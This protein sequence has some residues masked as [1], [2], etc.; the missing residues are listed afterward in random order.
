MRKYFFL[1]PLLALIFSCSDPDT[2]KRKINP[3]ARGLNDT[4][5]MLYQSGKMDNIWI[6]VGL[7]DSATKI[8]PDYFTAYWNKMLFLNKLKQYDRSLT[9]AKELSRLKP[10]DP[11]FYV[12]I[13]TL[14]EKTGDSLS[15][16]TSFQKG[17]KL[18]N[19]ELD[20]I[21][22]KSKGYEFM[23]MNKGIDL[24]MLD[25]EKEGNAILRQL[26]ETSTDSVRKKTI[27][28]YM[29]KSK[30]VLLDSLENYTRH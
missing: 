23:M 7:L 9:A 12:T 21:N 4:A 14:C 11:I 16:V 10:N 29:N 17:L 18:F 1:L 5:C 27:G 6:A 15:A 19:A 20:T 2:P 8:D 30:K 3:V 25:S 24:I 28:L 13:G 26:Y 22:P